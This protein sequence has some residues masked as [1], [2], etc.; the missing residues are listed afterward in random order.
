MFVC[1]QSKDKG[2]RYA[3]AVLVG[4]V[5]AGAGDHGPGSGTGGAG[6]R[7]ALVVADGPKVAFP[8]GVCSF[9]KSQAVQHAVELPELSLS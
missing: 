6:C 7:Q 2:S 5:P 9:D 4:A 8:A 1:P 3:P